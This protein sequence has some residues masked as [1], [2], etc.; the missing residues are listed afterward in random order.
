MRAIGCRIEAVSRSESS[1]A[2]TASLFILLCALACGGGQKGPPPFSAI[3]GSAGG[4]FTM[5]GGPTVIIPANA[6]GAQT[7][8]TIEETTKA[9]PAG[10]LSPIYRFGPDGTVF[11]KPV[12]VTFPLPAAATVAAVYWS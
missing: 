3:V 7:T 8:F 1:M 2:R 12:F 6:I 11:G 4:T 5:P 9:R 10:A